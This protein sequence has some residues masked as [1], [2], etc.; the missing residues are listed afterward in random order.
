VHAW[1]K[2]SCGASCWLGMHTM[3]CPHLHLFMMCQTAR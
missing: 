2:P 3:M 1:L